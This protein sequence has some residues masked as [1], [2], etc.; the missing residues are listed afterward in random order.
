MLARRERKKGETEARRSNNI[1]G[2]ER[3][4]REEEG[5]NFLLHQHQ[6]STKQSRELLKFFQP[7]AGYL[8]ICR[9]LRPP[10]S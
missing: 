3:K 8:P 9:L 4:R 5:K 1:Q 10:A 6:L 2:G 7:N